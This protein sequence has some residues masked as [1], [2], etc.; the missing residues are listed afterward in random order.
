[1]QYSEVSLLSKT[2]I[3]NL[4]SQTSFAQKN[5]SVI[6]LL[7]K[8]MDILKDDKKIMD[9]QK[10]WSLPS[11]PFNFMVK[12]NA[13]AIKF[14]EEYVASG[15]SGL[16]GISD[17]NIVQKERK[18]KTAYIDTR[19]KCSDAGAGKHD[20]GYSISLIFQSDVARKLMQGGMEKI[21][22]EMAQVI[23]ADIGRI[24]YTAYYLGGGIIS[25]E[26]IA[27]AAKW[28]YPDDIDLTGLIPGASWWTLLSAQHFSKLGGKEEI[29]KRAPCFAVH[30]ISTGTYEA[31]ALQLSPDPFDTR[32]D[33]YAILRQYLRPVLPPVNIYSLAFELNVGNIPLSRIKQLVTDEE[34]AQAESLR[35][36][37]NPELRSKSMEANKK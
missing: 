28:I 7:Q 37:S 23:S 30:D 19:I 35:S 10:V 29:M 18:G 17:W 26:S 6:H 21:V 33:D 13:D 34:L 22:E 4:V 12:Y 8:L 5:A 27:I 14:V 9:C 31:L 11:L 24:D 36:I 16:Y 32:E 3:V 20:Y 25:S 2:F 1:M 15:K